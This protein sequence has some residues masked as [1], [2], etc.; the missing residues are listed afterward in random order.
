MNSSLNGRQLHRILREEFHLEME[1]EAENYVL[2]LAAV[3][4]TEEGFRRLCEAVEEIERRESL[5]YREET[6]EK[7]PVKNSRMKQVMRISQAMDAECERY[8]LD[9]CI[10]RISAEFAYLYPPGIPLLVPG[11]QISGH[12]VKNVRRYLE[13]GFEVQGLS[14]Q[15]S[16]TICVVTNDM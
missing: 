5:K 16:E 9:E 15:T 3:G 7:E 4:D 14:D 13:Q 1:M 2:A 10:G 12:F 8:C 11:E 6:E